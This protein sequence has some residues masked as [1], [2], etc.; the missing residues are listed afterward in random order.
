MSRVPGGRR[1]MAGLLA[2]SLLMALAVLPAS[3]FHSR[4]S[5][6]GETSDC[7][8][9]QG[10]ATS[11]SDFYTC[12]L[13]VEFPAQPGL[14]CGEGCF[15]E[16][17]A[18]SVFTTTVTVF[19][20]DNLTQITTD[21]CAAVVPITLTLW[22]NGGGFAPLLPGES[23]TETAVGGEATFHFAVANPGSYYLEA[24]VSDETCGNTFN[25]GF[26]DTFS[27]TEG[28]VVTCP[29]TEPCTTDPIVSTGGTTVTI[30]G[31]AGATITAAFIPIAD[32]Q[33]T[34][35]KGQAPHDP[36]NVLSFD[37]DTGSK[38]LTVVVNGKPPITVCWN[39]PT[40]SFKQRDGKMSKFDSINGVFYGLL[41]NCKG[42]HPT[43]PCI[44]SVKSP[45]GSTTTT[46]KV[47]A[48]DGDPKS[49]Y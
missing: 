48:P 46:V 27:V 6:S 42:K 36:D 5:A 3:P 33:F 1:V 45:K 8:A 29:P 47:L 31:A 21:T 44:L 17:P 19:A 14:T 25:S 22:E 30:T 37:S 35:C 23:V 49:Q 9:S 12:L 11:G 10:G 20:S 16:I 7:S 26:S 32:A 43:G 28:V 18:G 15:L 39:T 41:P 38:T 13:R 24:T 40:A 2:S 34:A 4:V